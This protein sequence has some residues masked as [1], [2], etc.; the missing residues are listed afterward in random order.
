MRLRHRG[1]GALEDVGDQALIVGQG[2]L[3]AVDVAGRLAVDQ[4]Q[5]IGAV[6]PGDVDV[7]AE[8]DVALGAEDRAAAVAPGRKAVRGVPVDPDVAARALAAQQDLAE[9]L[10]LRRPGLA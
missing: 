5:V 6:A 2:R 7:L 10:E 4:E 8:L 3:P 1:L 9:V